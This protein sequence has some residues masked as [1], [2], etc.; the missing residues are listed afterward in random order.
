MYCPFFYRLTLIVIRSAIDLPLTRWDMQADESRIRWR[1][2]VADLAKI[3]SKS[4]LAR[5]LSVSPKEVARWIA[6]TSLPQGQNAE[7]ILAEAKLNL[8]SWHKYA[9][10]P[11]AYDLHRSYEANSIQGPSGLFSYE[12]GI[13]NIPC[14]FLGHELNSPIGVPA[15]VLTIDSRWI[16]PL[17]RMGYDVLTYKTVRS[18]QV[19]VYA[20][21]N[22]A[23]LPELTSPL[24]PINQERSSSTRGSFDRPAIPISEISLANSF[25]LPSPAP[26]EW[27]ADVAKVI[28]GLK[29]RQV[30]IVSVVGA[31]TGESDLVDDFVCCAHMASETRAHVIEL[32]L[33][34]PNAFVR[35]ERSIYRMPELAG[36][37]VSKVRRDLPNA[38]ILV[39]LGFLRPDELERLFSSTY[40]HVDGYTAI[41]TFPMKVITTG[42][43][44]QPIFPG[45]ERTKS[46]VSGVAVREFAMQTVKGLHVLREKYGK[47]ELAIVG[48]GGISQADHVIDLRAGGADVVQMCTSCIFDPTVGIE[49]R[50]RLAADGYGQPHSHSLGQRSSSVTF[51][52]QASATAFDITVEIAAEENVPFDIAYQAVQR[53]WLIPYLQEV[54][55]L[56]RNANGVARTR[57]HPPS[58]DQIRQWVRGEKNFK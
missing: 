23:Y 49:I 58:K 21:P 3:T 8:V 53:A 31:T 40:K 6:G 10:I 57:R 16:I 15:S 11:S 2:L 1:E 37:I 7:H 48:V 13:P 51:T 18:S 34:C 50:K 43:R 42:Q 54:E 28:G 30:L 20:F 44:E 35:E 41:N 27:Q 19:P 29:P 22:C 26:A 12:G 38:Q 47:R 45:I 33:S 36:K 14:S 17:S 46:G 4:Q 9:G 32:N 55:Q 39:K 24:S 25:G 52:D 56:Q 5:R